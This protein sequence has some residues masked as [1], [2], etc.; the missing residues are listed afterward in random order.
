[1]NGVYRKDQGV[2]EP[3]D[4]T[5]PRD[6]TTQVLGLGED[7]RPRDVALKFSANFTL[8]VLALL[9]IFTDTWIVSGGHVTTGP[10]RRMAAYVAF[11]ST[12]LLIVA[13]ISFMS[14]LVTVLTHTRL[15]HVR[16]R[17]DREE[18]IADQE[19]FVQALESA[20]LSVPVDWRN[21]FV[22]QLLRAEQI[23][24]NPALE[25]VVLRRLRS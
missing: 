25:E 22:E 12:A 13:L 16:E 8:V 2:S 23:S 15:Q 6:R 24:Q 18:A 14:A 5:V 17:A 3:S 21:E 19:A 4:S 7:L 10:G 9:V 20:L 11:I 1:M